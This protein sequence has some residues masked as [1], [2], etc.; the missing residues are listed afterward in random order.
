MI[1]AALIACVLSAA[2]PVF[3][4]ADEKPVRIYTFKEVGDIAQLNSSDIIRQKA[5]IEQAGINKESS[6]S[7]YQSQ[8]YNYYSDPNS[9]IS[10]SM[11]LNLQDSYEN[12]LNTY[13]DAEKTL[14]QLKPKVAYQAQ[15][16]YIDILQG[17]LQIQIQ[18]KEAQRLKSEYELAKVKTAFGAF[19]QAQ[20]ANA[21]TQWDNALDAL[22]KTKEAQKANRD[23]MREYLNIAAGVEFG[24]ENPPVFGQYENVFDGDEVMASALKKS[25]ALKQAQREVDELGERVRRYRSEGEFSQAD[26][27]ASSIPGK[28][29]ALKET[30]QSLIR[31]V[32]NML[33]E[34]NGLEAALEKAKQNLYETQKAL[35]ATKTR[36]GMGIATLNEVKT[37]EKAVLTAEKD[38]AQARY[39]CYLG[40]KK[41]MLLREGILVS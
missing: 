10:E 19:T 30:R 34:Y 24:L 37:A 12:A 3:A 15:K 32:E 35:M 8:V 36:Q 27:L 40:A 25:L 18:E 41:L 38:V 26:K 9:N 14:E 21:K 33:K 4:A 20:L 5:A 28:D 13:D 31:T 17:E 11:L 1:C 29:L 23:S 6:L 39:N 7:A 2:P 16:L 22:D